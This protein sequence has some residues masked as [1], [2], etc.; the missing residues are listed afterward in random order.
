MKQVRYGFVG[1]GMM[2]QEHIRNLKLIDGCSIAAIFE[3]DE[4]MR[5]QCAQLAPEAVFASSLDALLQ[6]EALDALVI[7]SPNFCHADQLR[8]IASM[9]SLPIL[10]EKP[11]YTD[12]AD[13]A[14]IKQ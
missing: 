8:E 10:C 13:E 2:G 11:L 9:R 5:A 14:T 4:N 6:I 3:P 12:T 1:C 7:T